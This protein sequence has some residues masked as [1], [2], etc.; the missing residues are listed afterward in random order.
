LYTFFMETSVALAGAYRERLRGRF[1]RYVQI[2]SS[3]DQEKADQGIIPSAEREFDLARVLEAELKTL[4]AQDVR[5]TE[6]CYVCARIAASPGCEHSPPVA[7]LAHL[8]TVNEVPAEHVRPVVSKTADGDERVTSDGTTLLGADDKAGVAEIMTLAE[9]LCARPEIPHGTIEIIF[10]PDEETG[11]GM[12]F[13]PLDWLTAK[14]CYTLDGGQAAELQ[15]ECFNACKSEIVFTGIAR[16]TGTARPAMVNAVGMAADFVSF[17]P[18]HESPETTDGRQGF[19]APMKI[20]GRIERASVLLY[21]RDF[22]AQ[23]MQKR[24]QTVDML[25]KT[26]EQK[27]AGSSVAVTHTAQYVNMKET[28]DKYPE[29]A[30]LLAQAVRNIGLEPVFKPIRGGTDGSRLTELGIPTPNIFTGSGNHHSRSEW[31]SLNQMTQAVAALV[32]LVRLWGER[33]GT[34]G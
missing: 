27:Y 22:D 4:G 30:E 28:L 1:L 6:H 3:C 32:E 2:W 10:S 16:H 20:E 23:G 18:K 33:E 5:L 31:A 21:L 29:V 25:A 19:Y 12:D 9:I 14:R 26:V 7:F 11:H 24:L 17:L 34:G 8:D 13:V 15:T